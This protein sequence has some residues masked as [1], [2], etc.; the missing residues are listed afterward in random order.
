MAD[1]Y[2][3]DT[4]GLIAYF[5]DIFTQDKRLS[6]KIASVVSEAIFSRGT[7]VRLVVPSVVFV[8]VFEKWLTNE[9]ILRRFYYEAFVPIDES[10]NIEIR[11]IEQEVL[12]A[13][14]TVGDR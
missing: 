7:P 13:L 14:L 8:E 4:S 2:V 5:T 3:L 11:P 12:E 10:P 6:K 1:R 9:E